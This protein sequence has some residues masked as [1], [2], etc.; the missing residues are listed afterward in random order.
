M[1]LGQQH[2][3]EQAVVA[4]PLLAAIQRH[5]QQVRPRQILEHSR[6]PAQLKHRVAQRPAHALQHRGPGQERPLPPGDPRQELRLY[7]L[8]H[9][10]V[11]PA[12]GNRRPGQRATLPQVQ[13][14]QIQPDRPPLGA[15]VQFG[16]IILAQAQVHVLQQR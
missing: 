15:P 16:H 10:P 1:Q 8:A 6:G 7:V 14:R 12:E 11:I 3:T 2:V 4:I 9:Q 13:R 5:Q